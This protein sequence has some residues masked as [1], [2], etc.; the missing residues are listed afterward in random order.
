MTVKEFHEM[1]TAGAEKYIDRKSN[2]RFLLD[3]R[4]SEP[5]QDFSDNWALYRKY[6]GCKV[7]SVWALVDHDGK[8]V[9]VVEYDSSKT[10]PDDDKLVTCRNRD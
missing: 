1:C 8:P 4:K 2:I 3:Y 9:I 5:D 10:P 6:G 7:E